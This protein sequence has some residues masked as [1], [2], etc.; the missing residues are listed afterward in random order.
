M[1]DD[2]ELCKLSKSKLKIYEDE[3][4]FSVLSQKP[5]FHG[6]TII[7]PKK[8][9]P[10]LEQAPDKDISEMFL[11]ANKIS[12]S[13]FEIMNIQGT[14]IIIENG[15]AAGQKYPHLSIHI[16]PRTENDGL[17]LDWKPKQL[18]EEEMSTVELKLKEEMGT[19]GITEVDKDKPIK[20]EEKV[21]K[22]K[23]DDNNYLLKQLRRIP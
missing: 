16:V 18:N 4:F 17:N 2:C 8:H 10:I 11:L 12:S 20:I 3:T 7:I 21:E 5:S 19:V 6:H 15:I 9:Y 13:L 1:G 23:D 22:I 14:N